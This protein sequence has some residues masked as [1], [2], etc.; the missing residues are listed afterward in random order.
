LFQ[1]SGGSTI[2]RKVVML[3]RISV[4]IE[5]LLISVLG[6][7]N[8]FGMT[9]RQCL[10][11]LFFAVANSVFEVEAIPDSRLLPSKNR[12]KAATIQLRA[13]SACEFQ[14]SRHDVLQAHRL[15]GAQARLKLQSR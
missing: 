6:P 7:P 9:I 15:F 11:S 14:Q 1:K 13:L 4:E 3:S 2:F 5:Q 12:Y 10:E 8:V